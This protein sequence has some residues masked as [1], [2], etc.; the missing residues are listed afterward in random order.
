MIKSLKDNLGNKFNIS[1]AEVEDQDQWQF[2]EIGIAA[3]QLQR[4]GLTSLGDMRRKMFADY[5]ARQ[6]WPPA[7]SAT[8]AHRWWRRSSAARTASWC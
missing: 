7:R 5:C 4:A 8:W 3:E 6:G 1:V 2:A